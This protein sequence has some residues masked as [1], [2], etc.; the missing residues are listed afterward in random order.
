MASLSPP[1]TTAERYGAPVMWMVNFAEAQRLP[2]HA[3]TLGEQ[4]AAGVTDRAGERLGVDPAA[5]DGE[6]VAG[7]V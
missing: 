5:G 2:A 6:G 7:G 4:D 3:V 1:F